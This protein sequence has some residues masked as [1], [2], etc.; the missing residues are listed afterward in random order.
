MNEQ[1]D[2]LVGWS[3]SA[4]PVMKQHQHVTYDHPKGYYPTLLRP[5]LGTRWMTLDVS[6]TCLGRAP[7]RPFEPQAIDSSSFKRQLKVFDQK[8]LNKIDDVLYIRKTG[9]RQLQT[10]AFTED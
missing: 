10:P 7:Y 8:F 3:T 9:L 6:S 5:P 1:D 2:V 4:D